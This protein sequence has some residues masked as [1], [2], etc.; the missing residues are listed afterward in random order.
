MNSNEGRKTA[1]KALRKLA[2]SEYTFPLFYPKYFIYMTYSV[3]PPMTVLPHSHPA[4]WVRWSD[5]DFWNWKETNIPDVMNLKEWSKW[6]KTRSKPTN[7]PILKGGILMKLTV[8]QIFKEFPAFYGTWR[9][10]T[11]FTTAYNLSLY[12]ATWIQSRPSQP[13]SLRSIVTLFF[14]LRFGLPS[15]LFLSS[16]SGQ[17]FVHIYHLPIFVKLVQINSEIKYR[18]SSLFRWMSFWN[19][20]LLWNRS[21]ICFFY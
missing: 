11:V 10:I 19:I 1:K 16:L 3:H 14:H 13:I 7:K 5:F 20:F 8:A 18:L 12:W 17:I 6:L 9:F 15:V 21:C 4:L 2:S